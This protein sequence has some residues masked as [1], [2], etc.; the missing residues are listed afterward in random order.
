MK[1]INSIFIV[2][3]DPITVFGIRKMLDTS[4]TFNSISTHVNGQL[5]IDSIK[6]IIDA[7]EKTPEVIFLDINM[8]IMDGWQFL[9]EFV[10]LP[11]KETIIINIVTSSIDPVDYENW[12]F[13]KKKTHHL[14][15]FNNKPI[16]KE[17]IVEITRPVA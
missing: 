12:E 9:A 4:V 5:A 7:A 16:T 1:K 8:P 10:E 6:K 14:I 15:R 2:D 17:R 3:D 13:Y 11:I